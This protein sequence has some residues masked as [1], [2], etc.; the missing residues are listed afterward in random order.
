MVENPSPLLLSRAAAMSAGI[1]GAR[2]FLEKG[3]RRV[4]RSDLNEI[5]RG[6]PF[7]VTLLSLGFLAVIVFW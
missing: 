7:F 3:R 5:A 6:I 2:L 1:R 4:K